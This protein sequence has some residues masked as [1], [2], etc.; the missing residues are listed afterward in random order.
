[1]S[2]RQGIVTAL[3]GIGAEAVEKNVTNHRQ[4]RFE[5][6]HAFTFNV[7]RSTF[8]FQTF[9]VAERVYAAQPTISPFATTHDAPT[10]VETVSIFP[11]PP[12]PITARP[13]AGTHV[14]V[15]DAEFP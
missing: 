8:N 5:G 12:I 3:K 6:V 7:Q 14:P 2:T 13:V 10:T 9:N 15:A 1:M 4:A 11:N